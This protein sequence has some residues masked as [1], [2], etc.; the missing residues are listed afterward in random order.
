M[1][2]SFNLNDSAYITVDAAA[3]LIPCF[4]RRILYHVV[5]WNAAIKQTVNSVHNIT[6]VH[7]IGMLVWQHVSVFL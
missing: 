2:I 4:P 6:I 5:K 7:D 1:K 3:I